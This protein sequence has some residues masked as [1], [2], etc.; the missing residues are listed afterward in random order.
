MALKKKNYD[1][2]YQFGATA[3]MVNTTAAITLDD[4]FSGRIIVLNAA[5]GFAVTLPSPNS[6]DE[7]TFLVKT[8]P[9]SGTYTVVATGAII[10][11]GTTNAAAGAASTTTGGTTITF[12]QNQ[13]IA[14]DWVKLISDG[15]YW[16][17][18]GYGAVAAGITVA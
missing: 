7:Y 13:S 10:K 17:M 9:T 11:G 18:T 1:P 3:S 14:G 4:E 12:A 5:A 15:T 16:Y 2:A 6:G 8:A